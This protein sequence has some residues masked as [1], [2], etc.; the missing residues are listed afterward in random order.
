MY[1]EKKGLINNKLVNIIHKI[2][3]KV[4]KAQNYC[5]AR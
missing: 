3:T 1:L 4:S 2:N 5:T